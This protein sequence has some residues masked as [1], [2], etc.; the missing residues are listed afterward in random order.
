MIDTP[1]HQ[2]LRYKLV[3]ELSL[4]GIY[5]TKVL[6]AISKVP[7]H[8][9]LDSAF[10]EHA[11]VDKAFPI[12]SG[13]TISQPYTVAFQTQLL[14]IN[15]GDKIL[16]IGTG[17]G[18]QAAILIQM[19][20]QVYTIERIK[21]LFLKAKQNLNKIGLK[22]KY[23]AYGDGYKGLPNYA[24]FDK[25]IVTAA[26]PYIPNTLIEQLKPGGRLVIPVGNDV[27]KMKLVIKTNAE[28]YTETEHGLFRFVPLLKNKI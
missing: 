12:N 5:D 17:S 18:Y 25:I 2:G 20:A 15:K 24:P 27:Q 8:L 28:N 23:A 22:P 1:R 9:F 19:G 26:A 14:E 11:Y 10:E 6:E 7:R 21:E 4:K 3:K 13:Q 16:E